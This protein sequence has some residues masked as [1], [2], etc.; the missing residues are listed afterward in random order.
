[1][2]EHHYLVR[3]EVYDIFFS[4]EFKPVFQ[5][6]SAELCEQ[7]LLFEEVVGLDF[8]IIPLLVELDHL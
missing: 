4:I 3:E 1:M 8:L 5:T 2:I 6:V 7:L